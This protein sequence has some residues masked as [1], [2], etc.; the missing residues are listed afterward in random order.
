MLKRIEGPNRPC[1]S[2]TYQIIRHIKNSVTTNGVLIQ[3]ARLQHLYLSLQMSFRYRSDV[4]K[5]LSGNRDG[6]LTGGVD[7]AKKKKVVEAIIMN[8][9]FLTV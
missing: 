4:S 7:Y 1:S 5:Q 3:H 9:L 2:G 6:T 8:D